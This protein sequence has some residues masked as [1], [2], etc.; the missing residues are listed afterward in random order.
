MT[1]SSK[2]SETSLRQRLMAGLLLVALVATSGSL[3]LSIGLGLVPCRLC[4]FQRIFM[5]PLVAI[6]LYAFYR[7]ELF[8]PLIGVLS[9]IGLVIALYH[10]YIQIAPSDAVCSTMCSAVLYSL[11]PLSIP[12]LS[13]IAFTLILSGTILSRY[14]GLHRSN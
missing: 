13:A 11:G 2:V 7:D 5:Y 3:Y 14:Y 8:T 6:T 10:S 9:S 1:F 12:N 4:W